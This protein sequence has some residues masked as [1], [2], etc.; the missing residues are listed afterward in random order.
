MPKLLSYCHLTALFLF[1]LNACSDQ[2]AENRYQ[3]EGFSVVPAE[4]WMFS[5]DTNDS[6]FGEREIIFR[7]GDISFVAFY[8]QSKPSS[9]EDFIDFYLK[10]TQPNIL[11][12][13][14]QINRLNKKVAGYDVII[15]N[16]TSQFAGVPEITTLYSVK[17]PSNTKDIYFMSLIT[18]EDKVAIEEELE[19]VLKSLQLD[20]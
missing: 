14:T 11:N 5:K 17:I 19:P 16:I 20:L 3:S 7:L 18:A 1:F 6:L 8:V 15:T 10:K 12:T 4:S 13:D 9:F 2:N